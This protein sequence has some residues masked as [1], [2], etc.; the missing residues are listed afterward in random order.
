MIFFF[1]FFSS[2]SV[3]H[4]RAARNLSEIR[5]LFC[6]S[7][8]WAPTCL[9]QAWKDKIQRNAKWGRTM[10]DSLHINTLPTAPSETGDDVLLRSK[11]NKILKIWAEYDGDFFFS[12]H[13][14]RSSFTR[15]SDRH[16]H[17]A[18]GRSQREVQVE[19]RQD[20]EDEEEE[21]R[22]CKK[23]CRLLTG[24]SA[25]ALQRITS[26]AAPHLALHTCPKQQVRLPR[27]HSC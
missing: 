15:L 6:F 19:L 17:T 3:K 11:P 8:H 27:V 9:L 26:G 7:C 12:N 25:D 2:Q 24:T 18:R 16:D 14:E 21:S 1:F 10:T 23:Y 22:G 20:D 4:F 13:I 5:L